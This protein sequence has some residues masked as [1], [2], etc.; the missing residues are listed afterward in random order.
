MIER[1]LY[2]GERS[3]LLG[4]LT[5][6]AAPHP[7]S[8]AVILLNAGL[9]HR[10]GPNRLHVDVARRLA[11]AGFT[12]LRFDMSGVGDSELPG[13]GG[14]LDIERSRQD[15]IEA[16]DMLAAHR[17][18]DRFVVMGLCTGAF[19]AFRAALID[20]RI[21]GCALLD[22]YSYPTLRS[23][24]QHYGSRFVQLDRWKRFLAHRLG[25]A[26]EATTGVGGDVIVFENEVVTKDRFERELRSLLARHTE[27]LLIYTGLGP[28]SYYYERQ[29]FDAF[30]DL[31]LEQSATVHFYPEAD[32]TFTLPGNR[33][34][35][36]EHISTWMAATF[37]PVAQGDE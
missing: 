2:F 13:D 36:I 3:N 9:L 18:I 31:D 23:N 15:V 4:V 24:L 21:V 16:M 12:S 25:R 14:L 34:R 19:N 1:P 8:P 26:G 28:L 10:V 11:E 5:A 32:H 29:I 20:D 6:P 33:L 17:S 7:G 35:L 22:G 30:P 37:T 27:L